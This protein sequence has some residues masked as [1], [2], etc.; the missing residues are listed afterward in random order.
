MC[1]HPSL[2]QTSPFVGEPS[3][4]GKL[5]LLGGRQ[6]VS[7]CLSSPSLCPSSPGTISNKASWK[8]PVRRYIPCSL[9]GTFMASV[10]VGS[11]AKVGRWENWGTR[12]R[13]EGGSGS[14]WTFVSSRGEGPSGRQGGWRVV[15]RFSLQLGIFL[16]DQH[17][18]Q[19]LSSLHHLSD[20]VLGKAQL[21]RESTA[22]KHSSFE[23]Q[24]LNTCVL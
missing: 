8:R 15:R 18:H 16:L 6:G 17:R 11:G 20:P 5:G 22:E 4:L 9:G 13:E 19:W 10:P 7:V 24:L 2:L 23:G 12:G 21:K 14:K 1:T 3:S